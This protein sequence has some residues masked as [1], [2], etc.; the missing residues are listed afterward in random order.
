MMIDG[1]R[2]IVIE[3]VVLGSLDKLGMLILQPVSTEIAA[4]LTE[5]GICLEQTPN[6][7]YLVIGWHE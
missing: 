7:W 6:G 5:R 4:H 2:A 1:D 3:D